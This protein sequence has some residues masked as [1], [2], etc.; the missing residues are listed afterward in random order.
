MVSHEISTMFSL[1]CDISFMPTNDPKI[2]FRLSQIT[3]SNKIGSV[4]KLSIFMKLPP[5]RIEYEI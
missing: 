4:L 3:E 1:K 5:F 2:M